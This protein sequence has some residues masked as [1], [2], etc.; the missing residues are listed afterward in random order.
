M[1]LFGQDSKASDPTTQTEQKSLFEDESGPAA[2][3]HS[4]LFD[5]NGDGTQSPWSM[6]T[7]KKTARSDLVKTLLPAAA[8]PESYIDAYDALLESEFKTTSGKIGLPGA[9]KLLES[10]GIDNAE[11]SRIL[12]LVINGQENASEIGRNELHVLLALIGLSQ[13]QEEVSLDGVDERRGSENCHDL[14]PQLMAD[15]DLECC[16]PSS[17]LTT[18]N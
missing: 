5:D 15:T 7:P 8:V 18:L 6:P 14:F 2:K 13:E 12:N 10:S 1:S 3:S 16:R 4:S 17:T 9:K 11:Q